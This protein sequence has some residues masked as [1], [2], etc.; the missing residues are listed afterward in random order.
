MTNMAS[1]RKFFD[2]EAV[3]SDSDTESENGSLNDYDMDDPFMQN[4]DS[5]EYEG[6]SENSISNNESDD[7]LDD[8]FST[9]AKAVRVTVNSIS[10]KT[11]TKSG[12]V[13]KRARGRPKKNQLSPVT[14]VCT[15]QDSLSS[16]AAVE[17]VIFSP[18]Q[19]DPEPVIT[20]TN[21]SADRKKTTVKKNTTKPQL[22]P[23]GDGCYDV[24]GFSL[25]VAKINGDVPLNYI[26]ITGKFIEDYCIRG[27]ASG[28]VG[29]RAHNLHVQAV[30]EA[31]Y[32]TSEKHMKQLKSIIKALY[33]VTKGY[34]IMV[35][36]FR[37]S[38]NFSNMIGYC[39][40]DK[41]KP[42]FRSV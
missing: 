36:K 1:K 21:S 40:K 33:P 31:R 17:S 24:N 12:P 37:G 26:D 18:L 2:D 19:S 25:T 20:V 22:K 3:A 7:D 34:K 23:F 35:V 8:E 14:A 39:T 11:V 42:H 15:H 30:F 27:M 5:I 29:S 32:A 4:D 10:K 38:Q 6:N 13:A 41:D 9:D 16:A 28:E